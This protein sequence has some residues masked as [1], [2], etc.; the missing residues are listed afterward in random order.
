MSLASSVSV[1]IQSTAAVFL[2][3]VGTFVIGF[4]QRII[5]FHLLAL[6]IC[7]ILSETKSYLY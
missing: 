2:N 7:L 6:L 4:F 5:A 3:P 1:R